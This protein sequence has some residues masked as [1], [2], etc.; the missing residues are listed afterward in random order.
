[1]KK[2]ILLLGMIIQLTATATWAHHLKETLTDSQPHSAGAHAVRQMLHAK[3]LLQH[4]ELANLTTNDS[5][6]KVHHGSFNL[7]GKKYR[8]DYL[9]GKAHGKGELILKNG[10]TYTGHF[11]NGKA[12]GLFK[13]KIKSGR[14]MLIAYRDGK[15][16]SNL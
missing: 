12:E 5:D 9:N 15:I 6:G 4:I 8:G 14:V 16:L 13:I 11:K 7:N 2:T 3:H 10:Q 1:M